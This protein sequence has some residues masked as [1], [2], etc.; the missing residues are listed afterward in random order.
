MNRQPT[1]ILGTVLDGDLDAMFVPGPRGRLGRRH[2][3]GPTWDQLTQHVILIG[4]TGTGKTVTL[5]RLAQ[6][7]MHL[8]GAN[9]GEPPPR[10]LYLVSAATANCP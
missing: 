5:L 6:A 2:W 9:P 1:M 8:P 10:V 7:A 4:A 3:F